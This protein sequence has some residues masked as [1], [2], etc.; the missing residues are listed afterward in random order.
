M[1]HEAK[2]LYEEYRNLLASIDQR[3]R[4]NVDPGLVKD[5][6]CL[7]EAMESLGVE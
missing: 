5:I 2:T 1:K 7:I 4:G 6:T 3:R